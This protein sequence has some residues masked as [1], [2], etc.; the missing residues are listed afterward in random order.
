[1]GA[2]GDAK[3]IAIDPCPPIKPGKGNVITGTFH[4]EAGQTIDI[5][6]QGLDKPI[7]CTANHPFWSQTR[8]DFVE[9]GTLQPQEDL[10]LYDGQ[11]TKVIQILPRPGPE[12]VHNLEVLNEHVYYVENV[13]VLVHN[14]CEK[15]FNSNGKVRRYDGPKPQY[16]IN[17]AHVLGPNYNKNKTPL[18]PDAETVFAKA[19]PDDPDNPKVWVGRN[20][21]GQIYRYSMDHNRTNA[22]FSGID[23]LGDG[24]RNVNWEYVFLR[25]KESDSK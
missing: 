14:K 6:V 17:P 19:I 15:Y 8:Q 21:Q 11:I 20:D 1:M 2:Q 7:G 13:G 12:R 24:T 16:E 5:H 18:P 9:A 22:H 4:H 25:F 3:V 23:D 10:L